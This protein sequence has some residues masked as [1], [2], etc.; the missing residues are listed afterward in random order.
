LQ[1]EVLLG[2]VETEAERVA[3]LV[4]QVFDS[5]R[6]EADAFSY[7]FAELDV[8]ALAG[9]A[10]AAAR[11]GREVEVVLRLVGERTIVQ[12]DRERL[13]QA[14]ANL[15]ENAIKHAAGS[16]VEVEVAAPEGEVVV[17]VADHGEGIA[18]ADQELIFEQYGRVAGTAKP[19]AGL[20]LFIARSIAEAHGGTLGVSSARGAGATFSLRLPPA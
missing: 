9:E 14:L 20:G 12:G 19:G 2:V 1:R 13:R 7:V 8:A 5:A 17:S 10:V 15:I 6:I 11:A 16:P 4:G 18:P 3:G